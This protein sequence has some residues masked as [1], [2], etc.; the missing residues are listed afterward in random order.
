MKKLWILALAGLL[1]ACGGGESPAARW[2]DPS[3][4][5]ASCS[6]DAQRAS[7][8]AW[9]QDQYYWYPNLGAPD[10]TAT[11]MDAYFHSMLPNPPDRYSFTQSTQS[12]DQT[13]V[14]GW[15]SGY[16]YT[17][18]WD[19]AR[20]RVRNVE[21]E[22]PAAAAGI[23]RGDTIVS[24]DGFA[25][26]QI[27]AGALPTVTTA[28]ID[29]HFVLA[30]TGGSRRGVTVR[31]GLF[32]IVPLATWSTIDATRGGAP[33]KVGYMAYHQFTAY[34]AWDLALA[35]SR[36][37]A[38]RINELV[39]DLR[40]NG[41]GAVST[42]R[43]LA[44]MIG[45]S[46]TDGAVFTQLRFNDK[47]PEQNL[48][49]RFMTAQERYTAPI[50]GLNRVFVIT[51]GGTAS[52]SELLINGLRPF[53][54]VILVGERTYGK[55]YGFLPRSDCGTT[56][57]AVNFEAF[58]GQGQG[59]YADGMPADCP[60]ADDLDHPLG[61][62]QERRLQA[63]LAYIETGR[64]GAQAPQGAELVPARPR[65]FGETTPPEMFLDR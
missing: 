31:S 28:G 52:A 8:D 46:R 6:V 23:R 27:M 45:G 32:P 60:A 63:A 18:T 50:E 4:A 35:T 25:P 42:S 10:T 16:G 53:M 7:L 55:P 3:N 19:G 41:G 20:L 5:S 2:P 12:F 57:N 48:D 49:M 17:L 39:L 14:S 22:S 54:Q 36:M 65:V 40:Y 29:R 44:S 15:R 64:C 26:Q 58:N 34:T 13:F 62:T 24:I 51:S 1:Q 9:M 43:D 33:V 21:P 11:G 56:Y 37:A 61:D 38:Q 59:G 47:H 30:D